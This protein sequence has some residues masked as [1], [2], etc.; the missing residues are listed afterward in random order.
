MEH[1]LWTNPFKDGPPYYTQ[2]ILYLLKHLKIT[3]LPQIPREKWGSPVEQSTENKEESN[4]EIPQKICDDEAEVSQKTPKEK[5][6]D[7]QT[8]KTP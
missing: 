8:H 3:T 4:D 2:N 1:K 6:P 7:I 5:T